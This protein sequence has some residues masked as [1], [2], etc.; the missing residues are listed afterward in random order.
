MT[1]QADTSRPSNFVGGFVHRATLPC[2]S[3][4]G[5]GVIDGVACLCTRF[6]RTTVQVG[7]GGSVKVDDFYH[8]ASCGRCGF[9]RLEEVT[10]V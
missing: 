3:C 8:V 6:G 5:S 4:Y 1:F 7:C 10:K 2:P 9:V